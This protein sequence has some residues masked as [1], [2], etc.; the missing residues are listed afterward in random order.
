[1]FPPFNEILGYL[2]GNTTTTKEETEVVVLIT[3]HL[4]INPNEFDKL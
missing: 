4:L 2:F 3:P 1:M